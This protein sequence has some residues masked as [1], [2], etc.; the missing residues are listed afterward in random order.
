MKL[1]F[2]CLGNICRSP[3]AE[4]IM[5]K[6]A[7]H[8][9]I[10]SAGTSNYH[11]GNSPDRRMINTAK[12]YGL[13]I[14]TLSARQFEQNDFNRFDTIYVM[15]SS[16]FNDII[17][18]SQNDTHRQKVKFL[19]ADNQN[20]PDPYFGSNDGFDQVFRLIESACHQIYS[21]IE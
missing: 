18:L 8:F 1:L 12:K 10:D 20:V 11:I 5:K 13:D 3:L 9:I 7:P 15:D 6:I 4:G 14:S 17:R 2:V 16:N 21:S 19:L